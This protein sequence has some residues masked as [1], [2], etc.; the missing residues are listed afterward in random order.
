MNELE[1]KLVCMLSDANQK[2]D[3]LRREKEV[4]SCQLFKAL[5]DLDEL[6]EKLSICKD[7]NDELTTEL[8]TCKDE[9]NCAYFDITVL[10]TELNARCCECNEL[11]SSNIALREE[12]ADT[13][14]RLL[15]AYNDLKNLRLSKEEN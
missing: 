13:H 8:V 11:I 1:L 9:L 6:N 3:D 12:L 7:V 5:D 10:R 14:D 4:L 15:N 2:A